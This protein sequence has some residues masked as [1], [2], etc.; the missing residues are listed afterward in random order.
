M[1]PARADVL[2]VLQEE[3]NLAQQF[4]RTNVDVRGL[5]ETA[6][7]E[8]VSNG[9]DVYMTVESKKQGVRH[10]DNL[11]AALYDYLTLLGLR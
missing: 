8:K 10:Y 1:F 6:I 11:P 3:P 2:S 5:H 4:I 7:L 9:Y